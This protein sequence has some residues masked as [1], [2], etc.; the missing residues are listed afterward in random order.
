MGQKKV[1]KTSFNH[2]GLFAAM[3]AAALLGPVGAGCGGGSQSTA[4]HTKGVAPKPEPPE[5]SAKATRPALPASK[6]LSTATGIATDR[7]GDRAEVAV[8]MGEAVPVS[9]AEDEV[10]LACETKIFQLRSGPER[11]IAIPFT[12]SATV[13]SSLATDIVVNLN[14]FGAVREGG[15]VD[16]NGGE[17]FASLPLWAGGYSDGPTCTDWADIGNGA[18][19]VHWGSDVAR[20]HVKQTWSAWLILPNAITPR[21]PTG[22][23]EARLLVEQP[24]VTL[25]SLANFK[26][27]LDRSS[28]I[29]KCFSAYSL[30]PGDVAVMAEDTS[31][32][33]RSGCSATRATASDAGLGSNVDTDAIC[34]SRYPSG[35]IRS[36]DVKGGTETIYD[37]QASLRTVCAGFGAPDDL[38]LTPGMSCAL[39]AAAAVWGGPG[40]NAGASELCDT[41]AIVQGYSSKGWVGVASAA[42][43]EKACGY[44]SE[45]FAGGAGVVAAGAASETGPGAAAVG[46]GTYKALASFLHVACGGLLD[47]GASAL[48]TRLEA[49]HETHVAL[50]VTRHGKC[51]LLSQKTGLSGT[52]WH[53]VGCP[54]ATI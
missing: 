2:P 31:A 29:V 35:Q 8:E 52:S 38:R 4:S 34:N 41:T 37:R 28:G 6:I 39:I 50:D 26:L 30:I 45:V 51:L 43:E 49:N 5:N 13:L 10:L 53:A 48:G 7:E 22:A 47:G 12:V 14:S 18:G 9:E 54:R 19:S 42:A 11:S 25:S 1:A 24:V 36:V 17:S 27:D 23:E 16:P 44:F 20:P 3:L 33:I 46:L 32:A 40:V 21:D 15:D